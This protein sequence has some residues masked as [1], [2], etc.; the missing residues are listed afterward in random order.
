MP[1]DVIP[2]IYFAH[3]VDFPFYEPLQFRRFEHCDIGAVAE[4]GFNQLA[5]I[6]DRKMQG[7]AAVRVER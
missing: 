2:S 7:E 3:P 1:T 6:G 4:D 5:K